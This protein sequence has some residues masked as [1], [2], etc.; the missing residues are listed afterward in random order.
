VS[1]KSWL[2]HGRDRSSTGPSTSWRSW[3]LAGAAC[4]APSRA[5]PRGRQP[6]ASLGPWDACHSMTPFTGV[7]VDACGCAGKWVGRD[8]QENQDLPRQPAPSLERW[9]LPLLHSLPRECCSTTLSRRLHRFC[10]CPRRCPCRL[11]LP[12]C[13]LPHLFAYL[14]RHR[15]QGRRPR[16][17]RCSH[18]RLLLPTNHQGRHLA[19]S[20]AQASQHSW[21]RPRAAASSSGHQPQELLALARPPAL[22]TVQSL[23][24]F[25]ANVV[26]HLIVTASSRRSRRCA[27]RLGRLALETASNSL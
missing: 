5:H 25:S 19:F 27:E 6:Q 20:R 7:C 8:E 13:Q 14:H 16:R 9:L 10:R 11:Q 12:R 26:H 2:E 1:A 3:R 4:G 17:P 23:P 15:P 22:A 21:L 18:Q 24:G